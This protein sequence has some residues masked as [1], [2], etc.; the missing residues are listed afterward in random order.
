VCLRVCKRP[1]LLLQAVAKDA[2]I[3]ALQEDAAAA[4]A[5]EQQRAPVDAT[6]VLL[7]SQLAETKQQLQAVAGERNAGVVEVR[8]LG[9]QLAQK[10]VSPCHT[11]RC[12]WPLHGRLHSCFRTYAVRPSAPRRRTLSCWRF[13]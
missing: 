1:L 9:Q 6:T 13:C 5:A 3:A 11:F 8:R 10:R 7:Q 12:V 2:V 4:A